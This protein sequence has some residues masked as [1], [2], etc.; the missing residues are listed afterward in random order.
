VS[1]VVSVRL[2]AEAARQIRALAAADHVGVSAEAAKLVAL[3]LATE[4]A[5]R[6]LAGLRSGR[7]TLWQAAAESGTDLWRFMDLARE[8]RT[9]I[10]YSQTDAEDDLRP[11]RRP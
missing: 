9:G 5:S 6:A 7:V 3:G 11:G 10:P 2:N 8:S 1:N 4:R